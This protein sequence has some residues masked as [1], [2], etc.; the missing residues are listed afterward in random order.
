M[1]KAIK[2]K[3][4]SVNKAGKES[5]LYFEHVKQDRVV[6]DISS[7]LPLFENGCQHQSCSGNSKVT[8]A[9]V[10]AGVMCLLEM[11]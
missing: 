7:L 3:F 2:E 1:T 5:N 6:V 4:S 8:T 9:K 11:H 10:E